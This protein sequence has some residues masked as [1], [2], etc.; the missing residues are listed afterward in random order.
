VVFQGFYDQL[1]LLLAQNQD[2]FTRGSLSDVSYIASQPANRC[3]L[4]YAAAKSYKDLIYSAAV[5]IFLTTGFAHFL[6]H[7]LTIFLR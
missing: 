7:E 2:A 1:R 5:S 3:P 4:I 6:E